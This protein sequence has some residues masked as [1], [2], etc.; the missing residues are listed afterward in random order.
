MANFTKAI[1]S[2]SLEA[3]AYLL[4]SALGLISKIQRKNFKDNPR[5][6]GKP[7]TGGLFSLARHINYGGYT[8][9][10]SAY[11]FTTGGTIP[12][13]VVGAFFAVDF[14]FRGIPVLDDYCTNRVCLV[15]YLKDAANVL[16]SM[17]LRGRSSRRRFLTSYCLEF[18]KTLQSYL[19]LRSTSQVV[20]CL[21][22]SIVYSKLT[23]DVKL[24]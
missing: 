17:V 7:Y 23:S 14:G 2:L 11:A 24:W 3:F 6:S 16:N 9:M 18:T 22:T 20:M 13:V 12:P 5:N 21:P 15:R 10:R 19:S 1:P 4:G 8:L